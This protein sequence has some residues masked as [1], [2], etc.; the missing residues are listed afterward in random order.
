MGRFAWAWLV[1]TVAFLVVGGFVVHG[2]AD[3]PVA[4]LDREL[5]RSAADTRSPT[6]NDLAQLGSGLAD[7]FFVI[8]VVIVVCV[9]F[10]VK[11]RRPD[12]GPLLVG[13]LL[14][15]KAV[16]VTVTYVIDRST[17]AADRRATSPTP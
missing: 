16:F 4:D 10:W 2:L 9:L 13:A 15:E 14:W 17:W 12:E 7:S 1:L 8:P 11:W 3:G 5:A 6:V